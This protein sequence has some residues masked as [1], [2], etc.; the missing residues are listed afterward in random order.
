MQHLEDDNHKLREEVF[1]LQAENM[2]LSRCA[3]LDV[4]GRVSVR[5]EV[6]PVNCKTS[7]SKGGQG[8]L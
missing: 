7:P 4:Q 3:E 6:D 2:Q 1:R 5:Q 8:N